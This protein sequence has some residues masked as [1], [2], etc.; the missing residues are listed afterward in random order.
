MHAGIL[1]S[2]TAPLEND[3]YLHGGFRANGDQV[4]T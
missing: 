2:R 3:Y 4:L 1:A